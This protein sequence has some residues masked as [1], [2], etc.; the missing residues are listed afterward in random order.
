MDDTP[1][2]DTLAPAKPAAPPA[3]PD[4]LFATLY[5]E[6]CRLGRRET[7]RLGAGTLVS[8]G[9]LVH[10]VWLSLHARPSLQ[11]AERG[12]FL[13]YA[14]RAMRGLIIDQLRAHTAQKR[15]GGL[16]ITSLTTDHAAEAMQP[17]EL[18]SV[19]EALDELAKL[20]PELAEVVDL[21]FFCGF[22][23]V[24]IAQMHQVSERTVQ[25]RWEKAR[26]LLHHALR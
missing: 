19:S 4:Q 13:A 11:F 7:R 2:L 9:T 16:I 3:S 1:C 5:A 25:R 20:E 12:Q 6:L 15:G 14:A 26:M 22:T 18:Q 8:T 23:L 24:E 21:K 17:Q 10:E